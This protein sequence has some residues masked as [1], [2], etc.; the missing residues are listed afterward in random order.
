MFNN[1]T[2]Y[3]AGYR[4]SKQAGY[5]VQVTTLVIHRVYLEPYDITILAVKGASQP[6]PIGSLRYNGKVVYNNNIVGCVAAVA[7]VLHVL[8]RRHGGLGPQETRQRNT[9]PGTQLLQLSSN[10][11]FISNNNLTEF[12][13]YRSR[14]LQIINIESNSNYNL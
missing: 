10:Y 14:N 2:G 8:P 12:E 9:I 4:I 5:L 6:T 11:L 13:Y 7:V 3:T 1:L